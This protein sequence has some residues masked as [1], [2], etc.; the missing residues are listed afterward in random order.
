MN[1]KK[2]RS[3]GIMVLSVLLITPFLNLFSQNEAYAAD[4]FDQL[5]EKW[6]DYLTG[7]SD[8]DP[9]DP[10]IS[11][12]IEDLVTRVTNEKE[13]GFLQ[14]MNK[15]GEHEYLW[16][17]L[18]NHTGRPP[19][20]MT[21]SYE[22]LKDMALAYTMEGSSL[23][24]NSDLRE[25]IIYGLDWLYLNRYNESSSQYGNWWDWEIGSPMAIKD[26][27]VLMYEDLT[28]AQINNYTAAIDH[29]VDDPTI[30]TRYGI[31]A[32]GANRVDKALIIAVRGIVGKDSEKI[33]MA[34]D[35]L[36][37]LFNYVNKGDGF[38][39]D[40][41]FIQHNDI[42][43]TGSYGIVLLNHLVD[44]LYILHDSSWHVTN[45]GIDNVYQWAFESFQPLI[46]KGAMMDMV[47]GRAISRQGSSDHSNGRTVA[48][49]LLRLS[50]AAPSDI[51]KKLKSMVKHWVVKDTAF[52]K[53]YNNLSINDMI[54]VKSLMSNEAIE[55]R[56]E[57]IGHYQFSS[58]DRIVHRRPGWTFGISMYSNRIQ[59]YETGNRENLK[60][61]YTGSGMT[62]LYNNDLTQYSDDFW[63][64]ID[65]LRLP[66][67]TTD[68]KQKP[69]TRSAESW[70]GGST[71]NGLYGTTGMAFNYEE[72]TLEG[73]KSWFMFDNEVVA[74]GA[75][76]TSNNDREIETIIENRGLNESGD[77]TFTVNGDVRSSELGRSETVEN[78]RWAHLEGNVTNSDIGYYF[79]K[80]RDVSVLREE[81]IGSWT[82]INTNIFLTDE[83]FTRNYLS[84][85][86][87]HGTN[88]ENASYSYVLL[89][90]KN[91][92]ET[93][94]YS[95]DS[96]IQIIKNTNDI[97]AVKEKELGLTAM[98]FW[99]A[100]K[101]DNVRSHQPASVMVK[102]EGNI[103]T[104]S[105][106]DPTQSQNTLIIDVGKIGMEVISKDETVQ[107]LHKRPFTKVK[108]DVSGSMGRSHTIKLKYNS[109]V[110]EGLP[111]VYQPP[112][113]EEIN[114][115][116][117]ADTFVNGGSQANQNFGA[118]S[119]MVAKESPSAN[120]TRE[121]FLKFNL[122]SVEIEDK[123]V[124]AKI[125]VYA[126]NDKGP[127][128]V[129]AFGVNNDNWEELGVTWN[130]RPNMGD[131][132]SQSI[133]NQEWQYQSFDVTSFVKSQLDGDQ[134]V[135]I[136]LTGN[137]NWPVMNTKENESN[138]PYLE[139]IT[140]NP[141]KTPP[142]T[143]ENVKSGWE[144]TEQTVKL[145]ATDEESGVWR[146][147]Y[148]LDGGLLTKGDT[149]DITD[150]GIHELAYYSIDNAA[151][152]EEIKM[153]TVMID[154]T[155]PDIT[156]KELKNV[157][158][159]DKGS[160]HFNI[161]DSLS[162]VDSLE[163][164]LDGTKVEHPYTFDPISLS[165]GEHNVKV[166]AS[167]LAGNQTVKEFVFTVKMDVDHLD[168]AVNYANQQGWI[169]SQ[170]ILNSL[171]S[172]IKH[173]QKANGEKQIIN[174]LN[175]LE[176][177]VQAQSGKKIQ[178][179]FAELLLEDISYLKRSYDE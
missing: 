98:N 22:R 96:D 18:E 97:Q 94:Q 127:A 111:P 91:V 35:A 61:W 55:P 140:S 157:Y 40:G 120:F 4:E 106:S 118:R 144:K 70:V 102:K 30:L 20:Y 78:A 47:R 32:T 71:I 1:R 177:Q 24:Q 56:G 81:R 179:S 174:G 149:V 105:V 165:T 160:I 107:V 58:M 85:S 84:M 175:A 124:A 92:S 57:L 163:V 90:N 122:N 45:S 167:D 89:P 147:L 76:I 119:W 146:T 137:G 83:S 168:E 33:T 133:F 12:H 162:G 104:L 151:N 19:N 131:F 46:Y 67:T 51:E 103:L 75:G 41:S 125:H 158:R 54:M 5:R 52:E 72:G 112:V 95:Q 136:G 93:R 82:D 143:T 43:Y 153:S 178:A 156:P 17:D 148:S 63:P 21:E 3:I 134:E 36:S 77:N 10:D 117:V 37:Q 2:Y 130:N 132:I 99:K 176:N 159:T 13:T 173:I 60:G 152:I 68:L 7:G 116:P 172:K 123:I 16:D 101:V 150:E 29:F 38:Y 154:M 42:A 64:T 44:V 11:N 155:G 135:T 171:L 62:Y 100:G 69:D 114:L 141:D 26:I 39:K 34:R 14:T 28:S 59:N 88:P 138:Q 129:K 6:K 27:L 65:S 113:S 86:F 73:K 50:E 66:G 164:K 48:I 31:E 49:A 110:P 128:P 8:Y 170:G 126:Q 166:T 15:S 87:D 79:P 115:E 108:I 161:T 74:L 80:S 53:Y 23:Y 139:I 121:A 9:S 25:G 145:T 169:T 142:I 109:Q